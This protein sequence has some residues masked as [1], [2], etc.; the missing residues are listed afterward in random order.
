MNLL[1]FALAFT[2]YILAPTLSVASGDDTTIDDE[3]W[4]AALRGKQVEVRTC[5]ERY[6]LRALCEQLARDFTTASEVQSVAPEFTTATITDPRLRAQITSCIGDDMD[7]LLLLELP[8]AGLGRAQGPFAVYHVPAPTDGGEHERLLLQ[9]RGYVAEVET[10]KPGD[11]YGWTQYAL[12]ER[13][14]CRNRP[15]MG[16]YHGDNDT[17]KVTQYWDGVVRMQGQMF[18]YAVEEYPE[19]RGNFYV[20]LI[21]VAR[22]RFDVKH[23]PIVVSFIAR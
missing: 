6:Y 5:D 17:T 1:I 23:H 16:F 14:T 21:D 12:V 7:R 20:R 9:I 15:A 2:G 18:L 4:R 11:M 13:T 3:G 19:S 22:Y 8:Q 10:A